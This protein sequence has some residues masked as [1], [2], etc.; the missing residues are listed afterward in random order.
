MSQTPPCRCLVPAVKGN[1]RVRQRRKSMRGILPVLHGKAGKAEKA[2]GGDNPP[3]AP[4]VPP[5]GFAVSAAAGSWERAGKKCCRFKGKACLSP[6]QGPERKVGSR[7]RC[8]VF[9]AVWSC[10]FCPAS[11][12]RALSAGVCCR[13]RLRWPTAVSAC[14]ETAVLTERIS[15]W[16]G[17][18]TQRPG[19][20]SGRFGHGKPSK[21]GERRCV[22]GAWESSEGR[23][24]ALRKRYLGRT[25]CQGEK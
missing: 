17:T 7:T 20:V 19:V 8:R 25:R 4:L 2:C 1:A 15:R 23:P 16:W 14:A 6:L 5:C 10:A 21:E 3:R 22:A 11:S 24:T 12:W 18:V 9:S 13:T